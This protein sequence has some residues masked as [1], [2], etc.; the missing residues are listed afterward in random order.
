MPVGGGLASAHICSLHPE[1]KTQDLPTVAKANNCPGK[2]SCFSS[3]C[4]PARPQLCL[5]HSINYNCTSA[6]K[7]MSNTN[8]ALDLGPRLYSTSSTACTKNKA[9]AG[10]KAHLGLLANLI[11]WLPEFLKPLMRDCHQILLTKPFLPTF[12]GIPTL[13][14]LRALAESNTTVVW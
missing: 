2:F 12:Q 11:P 5:K 9:G 7:L 6:T 10:Q 14:K 13:D 1:G 4:S 3:A 8:P